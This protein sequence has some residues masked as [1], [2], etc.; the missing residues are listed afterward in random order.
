M[1]RPFSM[2]TILQKK[3]ENALFKNGLSMSHHHNQRHTKAGTHTLATKAFARSHP[4]RLGNIPEKKRI[5]FAG[6]VV[7]VVVVVVVLHRPAQT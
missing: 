6:L 1:K 2:H 4:A 3:S 7:V 5:P